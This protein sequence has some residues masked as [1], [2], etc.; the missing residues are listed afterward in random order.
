MDDDG[1]N[2]SQSFGSNSSR[3]TKYLKIKKEMVKFLSRVADK[4]KPLFVFN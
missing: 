1:D 3:N 2:S 4:N